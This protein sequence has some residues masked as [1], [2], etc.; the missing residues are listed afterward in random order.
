MPPPAPSTVS[1]DVSVVLTLKWDAV[2]G[3]A[4]GPLSCATVPSGPPAA[5][6]W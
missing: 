6:W 4:Y 5:R 3:A 2:S 1:A